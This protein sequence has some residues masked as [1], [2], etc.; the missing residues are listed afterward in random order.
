[1]AQTLG[2]RTTRN[3]EA[4]RPPFRPTQ[5]RPGPHCFGPCGCAAAAVLTA[6][7]GG[8]MRPPVNRV[9]GLEVQTGFRILA[10]FRA[11][12]RGRLAALP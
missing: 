6:R 10:G 9:A 11:E 7:S 3:H 2:A 5:G 12:A 4:R 8:G 1:M